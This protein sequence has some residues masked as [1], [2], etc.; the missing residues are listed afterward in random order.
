[1]AQKTS[2]G[3]SATPAAKYNVSLF[4]NKTQAVKILLPHLDSIPHMFNYQTSLGLALMRPP[5]NKD[6][7]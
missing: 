2:L 1:M 4:A 6:Y 5:T 7:S 3:L